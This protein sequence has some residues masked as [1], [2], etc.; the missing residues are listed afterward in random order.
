MVD[1]YFFLLVENPGGFEHVQGTDAVGHQGV[2]GLIEGDSNVTLSAEIVDLVG[3]ETQDQVREGLSVRQIAVMK[4]QSG[5]VVD[6]FVEMVDS[7]STK[8]R[9]ATD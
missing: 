1:P 9:T 8:T 2:D 6:V 3:F 4:Q 5:I 7:A